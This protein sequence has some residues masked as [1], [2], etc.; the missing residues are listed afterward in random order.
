MARHIKLGMEI[1]ISDYLDS[2]GTCQLEDVQA[3]VQEGLKEWWKKFDY[4]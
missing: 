1:F 2:N 3:D 4:I